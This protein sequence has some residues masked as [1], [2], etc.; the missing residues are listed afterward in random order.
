MMKEYR[1]LK[2]AIDMDD[3]QE[4]G[5]LNPRGVIEPINV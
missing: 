3:L 1:N 4:I 2:A 5:N